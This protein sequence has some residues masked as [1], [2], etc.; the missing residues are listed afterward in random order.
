MSMHRPRLLTPVISL[1]LGAACGGADVVAPAGSPAVAA[2]AS[3]PSRQVFQVPYEFDFSCSQ[4]FEATNIGIAT[5]RETIFYS[6]ATPVESLLHL[7]LRGAIT[8]TTTGKALRSSSDFTITTNLLTGESSVSGGQFHLVST[9]QGIVVL[10]AGTVRVDG[11]GNVTF[12]G[13]RHDFVD[14]NVD[15]AEC[16]AL[17]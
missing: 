8:N 4:G 5:G 6:G 3:T 7:S 15:P 11:D 10:D 14:G 12:E 1:L 13:G 17:S 2:A 16:A 9:G